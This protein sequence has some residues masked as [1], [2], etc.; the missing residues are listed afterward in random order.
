M[1]KSPA[2]SGWFDIVMADVAGYDDADSVNLIG[3]SR[4]S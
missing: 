4:N 2:T 1:S 3:R